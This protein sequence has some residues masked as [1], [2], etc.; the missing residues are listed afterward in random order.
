M[1][2]VNPIPAKGMH[3]H[4][5]GAGAHTSGNSGKKGPPAA[6]KVN[7]VRNASKSNR[8]RKVK[9]GVKKNSNRKFAENRKRSRQIMDFI[10]ARRVK[11]RKWNKRIHKVKASNSDKQSR[12]YER[13]A[14]RSTR[15]NNMIGFLLN[16]SG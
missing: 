15:N 6:G 11:N 12:M 16:N 10:H 8:L 7:P 1:T 14:K 2:R 4:T 13:V 9:D 3:G 5:A